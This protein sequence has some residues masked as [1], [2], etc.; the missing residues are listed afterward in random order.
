MSCDAA[1][2]ARERLIRM[3]RVGGHLPVTSSRGGTKYRMPAHLYA[4]LVTGAGPAGSR[5]ARDL[6]L[7]GLK[8]GLLED[9]PEIGKPCHCSGLVS[10]RTLELAGVGDN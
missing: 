8:V 6:A 7:A 1:G 4:S 9:H 10:P 2:E 5:T 3:R